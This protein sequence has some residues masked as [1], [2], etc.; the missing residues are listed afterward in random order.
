MTKAPRLHF[1]LQVHRRHV[2]DTCPDLP[3]KSTSLLRA[4]RFAV[5]GFWAAR[6][7]RFRV[8]RFSV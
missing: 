4:F 6:V 8:F 5:S 1:R 7:F 2:R 3:D